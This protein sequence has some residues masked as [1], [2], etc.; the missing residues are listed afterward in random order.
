MDKNTIVVFTSDHGYHLGEH[1][2]W[3]KRTLFDNATR[4]PLI[5]AG[6][7]INKNEKI[8][9]APVELVDIYPTLMELLDMDTPEFVSGKSFAPL[10]K[11]SNARVRESALTELG[12]N[13][14]YGAKVSGYSI[15]TERY[16]LTQWGYRG[17]L[18]FEL[19]DHKY[20]KQELNNLANLDSYKFI[21]DSLTNVLSYRIS[22][23]QRKPKGLEIIFDDAR[24]WR[25][26]REGFSQPK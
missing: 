9:G 25:E 24:E 4:V 5:V 6:P 3:Q 8:M 20:D 11:D 17:V 1:G 19:Y 2:H 22:E 23:A 16:R 15:K 7:G 18:G 14:G 13:T 12:V 26:P 21:K 10:L